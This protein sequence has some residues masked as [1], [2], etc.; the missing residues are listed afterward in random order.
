MMGVGRRLIS[1]DF[2]SP[3][4]GRKEW[5]YRF[6]TGSGRAGRTTVKRSSLPFARLQA[7]LRLRP[8]RALSSAEAT[9]ELT[10][11]QSDDNPPKALFRY[12]S[13]RPFRFCSHHDRNFTRSGDLTLEKVP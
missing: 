5:I 1:C 7:A 9:N 13:H 4:D 8:R 6:E 3:Q 11:Q 10:D 12:C 2:S